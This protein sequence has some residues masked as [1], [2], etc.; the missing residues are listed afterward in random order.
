MVKTF[1]CPKCGLQQV[2]L[3]HVVA[4]RCQMNKNKMTQLEIVDE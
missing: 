2:A 3:G 1:E 4:H